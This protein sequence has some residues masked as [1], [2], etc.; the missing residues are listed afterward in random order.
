MSRLLMALVA[1]LFLVQVSCSG[2]GVGGECTNDQGCDEGLICSAGSCTKDDTATDP[3]GVDTEEEDPTETPETPEDPEEPEDP[4]TPEEPEEPAAD[5]T[6]PVVTFDS[7]DAYEMITG[8]LSLQFSVSDEAGV[9]LDSVAASVEGVGP[10]A[11]N[12]VA[13]NTFAATVDINNFG[14]G[15]I[16]PLIL[17]SADDALGNHSEYARR[18]GVDNRLSVVTALSQSQILAGTEVTVSCAVRRALTPLTDVETQ[19]VVIP[20]VANLT[21]TSSGATFTPTTTGLYRVYC[22]TTD[23]AAMD[24][25]G[26]EVR[27]AAASPSSVETLIFDPEANAGDRV[28][29]ECR[30]FDTYGNQIISPQGFAIEVSN[31]V[32]TQYLGGQLF[33]ATAYIIGTYDVA[34]DLFGIVDAV[35]EQLIV[36]AAN[37]TVSTTLVSVNG[38]TPL[39]E[40]VVSPTDEITVHCSSTDAYGNTVA[41]I[42]THFSVIPSDGQLPVAYGVSQSTT[43]FSATKA[44]YLYA[45]CGVDDFNAEDDTPAR[46]EIA[47][48]LPFTWYLDLSS[49]DC[50]WSGRRL[51]LDIDV[52]DYWGNWIQ[53]PSV[54]VSTIPSGGV[55][56]EDDGVY[57]LGPDGDFDLT[58]SVDGPYHTGSVISDYVTNFRV[59]STPPVISITSPSRAEALV[60]GNISNP[61]L[62]ATITI[63]GTISDS[64]SGIST[65]SLNGAVLSTAG[66]PLSINLN[67]FQSSR[68]GLSVITAQA[69]DECG[70]FG[71]VAQSYLRSPLYFPAYTAANSSARAPYG[72]AAQLNQVVIDDGDRSDL[73]DL[74]SLGQASL[75]NQDFNAI[76]VPGQVLANKDMSVTDCGWFDF[77]ADSGYTIWRNPDASQTIQ[78]SGPTL[79]HLRAINGGVSMD[80]NIS[81]FSFPLRANGR[82]ILCAGVP[83]DLGPDIWVDA[84][85]GASSIDV[86]ADLGIFLS[87]GQTS[88]TVDGIN[89]NTQGLFLDVDCGW[90]NFLC[91]PIFDLVVPL[92]E[93]QIESA[94]EDAVR[95]AIPQ[96]LEQALNSF[97]LDASIP[98]PEPI[99][100]TLNLS[101]GLD[102]ISF[103]GPEGSGFGEIALYTQVYPSSLGVDASGQGAIRKNGDRPSFSSSA[104]SF[105]MGLKDDLINQ[106]LWAAWYGGSLD[107]PDAG[108]LLGQD[109]GDIS[110]S[111]EALSPP[112]LMP[113]TG[114]HQIEIGIGD[115]YISATVALPGFGDLS[116]NMYLS[117]IVGGTIDF[118]PTSNELIMSL[119]NTNPQIW[120]EITD[121]EEPALQGNMSLLFTEVMRMLLPQL[122]ES[123]VGSIPLPT[124]DVG[125]LAGLPQSEVWELHN[126]GI[127]RVSDYYRL[128]GSLD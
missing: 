47:A 123:I 5:L 49:Q 32:D 4:E 119:D 14:D 15:L 64:V 126:G 30:A 46:V 92:I 51:P 34:C 87:G 43:G 52:Y 23:G 48:G 1:L 19:V 108:G 103:S 38:S 113:G 9:N 26:K 7:P 21:V 93:G 120:V 61:T 77:E 98:I 66:A 68:W 37:P 112:V 29:V 56:T 54:S 84:I 90:A 35:P 36:G 25:D 88:V 86:D 85:A 3:T 60:A 99:N 95:D 6:G 33:S 10:V 80:V 81:N 111:F 117:G 59:D 73:D 11:L 58:I 122:L 115:A 17:I 94:L 125:G 109:L 121:I 50:Y 27:V 83:A 8:V 97:G 24:I 2:S 63:Q 69:E 105:G 22:S 62:D 75:Q 89:L 40:V 42:T 55:L 124:F 128:T 118:D 79:G 71:L 82:T 100:T 72:I 18:F 102:Y 96:L 78:W 104:Y 44:G 70:N 106:V 28:P 57:R 31:G 101:S 67:Q 13:E 116:L 114:G 12:A 127:E 39:I 41:G 16:F 110:L 45:V 76:I 107:I 91:D 20:S 74:A 53:E 65:A